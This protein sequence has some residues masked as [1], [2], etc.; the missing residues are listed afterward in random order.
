M[1]LFEWERRAELALG[2]E[3]EDLARQALLEKKANFKT[4][5]ESL[6]AEIGPS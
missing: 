1:R 4:H 5:W 3:R 6:Q 2:K